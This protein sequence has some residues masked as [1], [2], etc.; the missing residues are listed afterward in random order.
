MTL[1]DDTFRWRHGSSLTSINKTTIFDRVTRGSNSR[2]HHQE[3]A[4]SPRGGR[5]DEPERHEPRMR[6]DLR[7]PPLRRAAEPPQRSSDR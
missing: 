5:A 7:K 4:S 2:Y 1:R 3:T 6:D